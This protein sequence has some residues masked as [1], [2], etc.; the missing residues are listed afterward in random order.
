M[1]F[2]KSPYRARV[3]LLSLL[4]ILLALPVWMMGQSQAANGTIEGVVKDASG[5][6]IPGV[7]VII[8]NMESGLSRT[9]ITDD[10]G[11]FR[12]PLLRVGRYSV[13]AKLEGFAPYVQKGITLTVGKTV[14]LDII[15]KVKGTIPK[16]IRLALCILSK[17]LAITAFTPMYIGQRA[18]CSLDEP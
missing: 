9:V 2:Y 18:A 6:I 14:S 8:T 11:H 3:L 5:G 4:L 13:E 17:D 16:L 10:K 15:L 1:R 12:A 7:T